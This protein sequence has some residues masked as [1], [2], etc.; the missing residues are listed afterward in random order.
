MDSV[1]GQLKTGDRSMA[2][3]R[4]SHIGRIAKRRESSLMKCCR[5]DVFVRIEVR[6]KN[7]ICTCTDCPY[8]GAKIPRN[9]D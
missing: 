7:N 5:R 8:S 2:K 6:D 3:K 4:C 9:D 1:K